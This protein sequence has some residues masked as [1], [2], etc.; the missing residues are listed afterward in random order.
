[1]DAPPA[2]AP[3]PPSA[4]CP[5]GCSDQGRC[6]AGRCLCYRG[7]S[8]PDCGTR[9][10]GPGTACAQEIPSVR[11]RLLSR[12]PSSFRVS[13]PRP[14]GPVDGFRVSLVP[15]DAPDAALSQELPGSALTFEASGLEPGSSFELRVQARREQELGTAGTLRV[16]TLLAQTLPRRG[17]S[18]V[19]PVAS[20]PPPR[21]PVPAA[22]PG[23]PASPEAPLGSPGSLGSP[24]A[25]P[26]LP[27]APVSRGSPAAARSPG[28]PA[29]PLSPVSP[30]S[31]GSPPQ[32]PALPQA[33]VSPPAP[34]SPGLPG[35]PSLHDLGAKLA[36]YNGS[37]LQR[38]ES[39]LRATNFPL[40]DNQTVPVV[41]RA[42]LSYLLRRSPAVLRQQLLQQLPHP[43][44]HLMP[45]AAGE[46]LVD[47]EGLRGH[48]ETVVIRYRLLEEPEGAEGELW[49]PG[50][51]VLAQVPGLVPGARYRVE[52]HGL[53]RGHVSKSYTFLVTAGVGGTEEPPL[54]WEQM[55]EMELMEP[56]GV[57]AKEAEPAPPS[58]EP[59]AKPRLGKLKVSN[60][61][62]SSVQ[63]EWSVPEGTFDSFTVQYRDAQGQPQALAVDG[64]S[65]TVTVT[66]L[67]P[68]RR[69]K[70]NLYGVWGRKRVGLIST[71]TITA[72]TTKEE[73]PES[74]P[75]LGELRAPHVS[76]DSVQLEW[77]VPEGTF[78]S[79]T[80]QYR[81][82][83]G[84][85]QVVPV[86][87]ASRTLT[88]PGLSPSRRYKFNLYGL[89]GR[90][91]LGPVSTDTVT[92]PAPQEEEPQSKPVLGE[93]RAPH[94]TSD[95]VQ[96][97]WS[98]PEGTF[99]SFT[100]QYRDA[101][102]QPQVV[103]VDGA[104][105]T[106]TV[107]GLSP[108]RRY[109]FNLYGLWG[110]TRLG[111]VSTN[112]VTAPAPKEK[113]PTTKPRLGELMVSN[114]TSDS[115]QL[116]WSVP[117]GTF[118]SFT[119][120]YRDAQGQPQVVPVDGASR[121][122]TVPGLSPS[123]RYKFNLYGL[124]G[125]TRLGPVSTDTVTAPAPQEEVPQSKPVLGE[126]RVSNV[127]SD[128]VQL[129]WS[130]PEG[131]FDSFTLQYRDAQGQLQV[132]PMD[133]ASRT[134]TVP[135]L[136]PS[137][138]YKFNLYGLW[139]RTRLGP[140]S[141][142]TVT[143]PKEEEPALQPVLGELRAPH[144]TSDSVQ[145]EWSVPEGTFDSFTLQYR[146]AQG[147]PQVVPV[148]GASRTLTV[149]GLSPSRRYKFNLYGV[150]GRTRLGPVSTDTVTAPNPKEEEP[151]SQPVLGE[152]RAPHVTSDSV[153]L[154]WSVP[155]GT[156]D[157]FTLQYRDAQGQPQVVP[158]DGASRTLTVPGLS[159]S[160]RY[161]F[162]LYGVWGRTR[163]GP[164]STNTVTAPT[165]KEEEPQSKPVLG[166]LRVSNVTSDS[167]QL[168]WSVPEGTFDSFTLQYRDAQGQP[169]VVPV[170]G[171]SRTL[172]VPGLSPS[173][174]YKFN[175][176][177]LW[178]RTRLGPVSTDTVTVPAPREEEPA[179]KPVLGELR[180]PHV[181][182]DS[183]QLEWSIPEG[184]FDSFTLQYHDAQG[185]PQVVPV[186]G[187][188]RTLTV[189]GLSPSRHYKFNLY[190]LWG[191]TRL[192]P[193][194]TDTVTAPAPQ[195]EEP[196]LKPVLGELR[197]PHVTSDSVQLE[198]SIPEGSFDSFTLQYRDAQ[199]QPESVLFDG[200][201]RRVTVPGLSPSQRYNFNLYGVV[202][203]KRLGPVSLDIITA[204]KT[205]EEEPQLKPVLGELRASNVTSDFVQLEWSVP[206]GTFDS[207]T[208]QYR[209]A[210][211][212]PQ[213]VPVDGASRTLTVPGLSPSRRY[214]FNLYGLWGR[215]RLGPVSTDTI[216][217]PAPQ[218]E[219]PA[220]KP[221]LGE[222][223]APH[224]TSDSVQL[225]WSIPEGS[226][227]SFT[228]Q[229]RDAQGQPESVLL[230][231]ESRRVT[232]PGLS[233]SQLYNFYLYGVVGQKRLGPVSLDTITAPKTKE[234]EPQ[235]KP[236]L[237]ELRLAN[238]N[239]DSVQLEWS[240]PEG[241]FDSFTL[242]YRDAQ[243]QPQVVPVDGAS[244]TLTVPGLSPSRRYKFNL[245]GL[246]GRTRLGPV[247]TDTVR[248]P[249]PQE[250]EPALKPVLGELKAP[251]VTSD[252]VQLEWS[253]PEGTFDSFTL[254]YRDAQ[255]QPQVVPVEGAS[256]T[257]TVPGLSPSRRYKFNLYGLWG[258]T[259]L[260]PVSTD[261]VTA[262]KTKEEEPQ[263]K[264]VLGELRVSNITS[265]SVQLEW[266]VPEGTFDSFTLQYRDAQGQPQV[267]PVDGASRTLTVPGLSPS[268][269][270]KFNL[271]GLWGR[272]RLGPVSTDT[273]TAPT[274]KEEEPQSKPVL[275]ELRV[276]NVTSDSVQLEWSVPEGTFDSFTLQYRDAQG[277]PQVVPVDGASRTLTVPGLSPSRRYKFNLYGLWGRT[278]LGPIS[279]DTVTAP[280]PKEEE[281]QSKPVLGELRVSNI[282]SESVQLE[283]SVP[284]GTFDS[285]TLQYR[286]AQGQPQVVPVD[287]ASRTLTVPGLS[288]SRR[289]KFNLYG[290]WGRRRLGPVTA[291]TVTVPAPQEEEPALKPVLGEL[292]SP[293][294]TSDSVQ[295]EWS[296]PEGTFDSFTLQ[297]RD[298]QG[299]PQVVPVDGASRTLTVP[300]LSPSRR[301]K[302]NLY[303][304][305]GRTRLGPV[306]TDT[307]TA[308]APQEEEPALKPVLGELRAPHVTSD[309]VQLEWSIPEGS[310]DSFMLQYR[311]AQGQPESVLLDGESRRVTV[312]GLS[313][314]QRYNFYLYGV[315]GQKRLGPVSLDTITAPKT[316]EEEPQL[317]PVLGEL[318][319]SNVTSD[320]VQLEW[321][322][323]E[324][325]FDSFTLQYRDAQGQPHVV[326]VDGASRM[327]TVPGLSPSRRYKFNLYG[328]WGRTR[329]GP[330]STDTITVPAPQEEEPALKPVLGEL[331]APH[332][333]SDSVQL[334]WSIPEGSFDSFTLQYR[335][336]QGQPES[337]LLDGESR[338]VTVPG[339]S[340]S[341]RYNF[342]L[343]GVVGQKR[344]GPVSLNIITAPAPQEEEP[345]SKPA[346]GE[347]RV[348]NVTSDSVQLEW[349]VPEG[350]F[351]SFTLQYRDAQGQP[352]VVPVDGAS[353]ML[354]VPGLSPSRR[355]KFNLYGLW[356]H[357]RLGP[358]STD[359]V[360]APAPQEEEPALK[361]V[362]GE[363]RA[364]YVTSDSV[365]LEWSIPEGSFDSFTLQ[366]R[367]AQGQPESVLLD[368]ESR[369][370]TVPGLSPS[371]RYNFYLYGVVGQ[372]RLGPVSLDTIT[373][374]APQEKPPTK[375]VLG[376]L[377][378]PHVT[379]DSVQLEWSVPEG[380][381]DSFTLQYRDAQGQPQVVPVDGASR[382][383]TVPGL[384]PSR[385]YKFNLYGLWGRTRLGPVSTNTVTGAPGTIWVGTV[386]PRSARL[387]WDS[388][389]T[390]RGGYNL[391]YGPPGGGQQTLQLPPE[392]TS[393]EL[394]GL[395]PGGRYGV[396]LQG[397]GEDTPPT[398]LETTFDTPPLPHPHPQDC[399]EEQLNGPGPSREALIFLGGDP[400]RP[401]RVFCDM[402]T[403]GG[404]WL[405]FQR[406]QDGGTDFWRGWDEYERGFGNLS[407]EFWLGNAALHALTG[408]SPMELRID[409]RSPHDAAFARYRDFRVA[410]PEEHFRLQLGAYSGTAGDA[411]SYHAGSPFST[412]DRDPRGRPRPC[413][414]AYTGAWWYHNCHYAN[415]NGRYGTPLHHQA[416]ATGLRGYGG[417]G[418]YGGYVGYGGFGG[419]PP[420]SPQGITWFPWKG[421]EFSIPFT[422]MKLRPQRD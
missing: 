159:P 246:W 109:K 75:V 74:K 234:E 167:V 171:A 371:Q 402:D 348:S 364:P 351:D 255:G 90:T 269:R 298:A 394:W 388:P 360:T 100:L 16:R 24:A 179:L 323:P 422:E 194:S 278:R 207:F 243:G 174:R 151:A 123:R 208:L 339:L 403:D 291:N 370:V 308:P 160:R 366:Y 183:V 281:P 331:R 93:L 2:P 317:K 140:V 268:R 127:T 189:P 3:P 385:R 393:H 389:H 67:S 170:D 33:P 400:T 155:E 225:E 288:P 52:V 401:L 8:G 13:W 113:K 61:T 32:S 250:V 157:S 120:Q 398:F 303:G 226:F 343:Y 136:S 256:R 29:A 236:V 116:E 324:G 80:L 247:S 245:Y 353:R 265:D 344:L 410:G 112:T 154:E 47:L 357:R 248:V 381:F 147:Q 382:T 275:G 285:F 70:F 110:R 30:A 314:S 228:L 287:G 128:S 165:T 106:L 230:D 84:Q 322:V 347:L 20:L 86:D 249:A 408:A 358:I 218:E 36:S 133:G 386:W 406:R 15:L 185:Q 376:E 232:V 117:E 320:S 334:E 163:L 283:W 25:L 384:S 41:A 235:S 289:Y 414:I 310:F 172:T 217:A 191:H 26:R 333:T 342:Y 304:L 330:I 10:C 169:Q 216:T 88:V 87:G 14:A 273:V 263:S 377:R 361:P 81:D 92:A 46:V 354:M 59:P 49:V 257:L 1:P 368:G 213:V 219:E 296:V 164:V 395:E 369:R 294:V 201:S 6:R 239:S 142:D 23:S 122:L 121:T 290:L 362:L 227:D 22:S 312:P 329:L 39:H 111:P 259:R 4:P 280:N 409:L 150:W 336:A 156:F 221:V 396:Q 105:R 139:G 43:K 214:K 42:I 130:V 206:E 242:Q 211:G 115:V 272:T 11:P 297:Y 220:L 309:S 222:L 149:P 118:D 252:S 198:W 76:S 282:T 63:L 284:E 327:L 420:G 229:Y 416:W 365:Q 341:Q 231:G 340:P 55:N 267:V 254:Q 192:G 104:S 85:P 68:S 200:E 372:K 124:W 338:R 209:D 40:R 73:E 96:L 89:W 238:V 204:P 375:P 173:R 166:E 53:V 199:G 399:A 305:W 258:R 91:R 99:D 152:L 196:A 261:T 132:V 98:V 50:D 83:Q 38:L 180:A 131:T 177:G 335:D 355:Y 103:P 21:S 418:G 45:G 18:P 367:D 195:E 69:Y 345:Q 318:R 126:L 188:S 168:E 19:P 77:S 311:D 51:V 383:L 138:R 378:A 233:P 237:G 413:A 135:G 184:T 325:T 390:P 241:T 307:V 224:V 319:V 240:V 114:V 260:G 148:D 35:G 162:N 125:R 295:L 186:D 391:V 392:A 57:P 244:R 108:S 175:L 17:G 212:Q 178:G 274:T 64:G 197:A 54:G 66:G 37:L 417:N 337:V 328:L 302:F 264:P 350:T 352:Q 251:H 65:R 5:R 276:S 301:Y 141:T 405:V 387:H 144:I 181:T 58:E 270:Y 415:L 379:S 271:Y 107:P 7:F 31:P 205:K 411:L 349:S 71:D 97:E 94:V 56:Q 44:P 62:P 102:G 397:Q 48:A 158:V 321:S 332:V 153:Q 27:V 79:F 203:Q 193:V 419:H 187:A 363:L 12:T 78:D 202:G 346:L 286:D 215:T 356:G 293:H 119:L 190:G 176:Y 223:R 60:V 380:T 82:A 101:Q 412:R 374:A 72:P 313:P 373:A 299:Q 253:V 161:K 182:S 277:Q 95:S 279:T 262:P 315:V 134:L 137:R 421:F 28:S 210:Q 9:G 326:P 34:W 146:D 292:R 404:G 145:L 359:T 129:E 266:S 316:K 407:G 300:G 143:A 306:S